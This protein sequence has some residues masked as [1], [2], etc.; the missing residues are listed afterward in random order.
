MNAVRECIEGLHSYDRGQSQRQESRGSVG[1][2]YGFDEAFR[3][4]TSQQAAAEWGASPQRGNTP[5]LAWRAV[6]EILEVQ[7][8]SLDKIPQLPSASDYPLAKAAEQTDCTLEQ[9]QHPGRINQSSDRQF[10]F[11]EDLMDFSGCEVPGQLD[12]TLTAEQL[13][14]SPYPPGSLLNTTLPKS[15]IQSYQDATDVTCLPNGE[16]NNGMPFWDPAGLAHYENVVQ[17]QSFHPPMALTEGYW[18]AFRGFENPSFRRR[19]D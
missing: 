13:L 19:V 4:G 5:S 1:L 10:D 8:P 18:L 6:P 14:P 9:S 12:T 7:D 11:M 16:I 15:A 3:T 2:C 17:Q